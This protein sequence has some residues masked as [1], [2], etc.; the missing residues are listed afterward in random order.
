MSTPAWKDPKKLKIIGHT[1]PRDESQNEAVLAKRRA[2]HDMI[3]PPP[4]RLDDADKVIW[5][6]VRDR[7]VDAEA[8]FLDESHLPALEAFVGAV[9]VMRSARAQLAVDGLTKPGQ[10]SESVRHPAASIYFDASRAA[11]AWA[12]ELGLTP[13]AAARLIKAVRDE[14]NPFGDLDAFDGL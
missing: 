11:R 6:E 13:N 3:G 2:I 9:A 14:P 5:C 12:A 4:D 8:T 1:V 7:L 10:K